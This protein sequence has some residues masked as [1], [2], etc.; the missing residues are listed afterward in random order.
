MSTDTMKSRPSSAASRRS[1]FGVDRAGLPATV[2]SALIWPSPGV[3]ISSAMQATG[4]S[5]NVSGSPR[6]RLFQRP[7]GMPRPLPGLPV[8][9]LAPAAALVNIAPPGSSRLPVSRLSTST[10]QEAS[11]PNS[12][13]QVPIRP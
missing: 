6:T 9:F 5:P 10:S 11:V 3:S 2:I 1:A 13:V 7:I 8:A 12:C 4:S